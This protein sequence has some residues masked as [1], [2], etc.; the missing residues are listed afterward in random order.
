MAG[1]L[2]GPASLVGPGAPA[3][4]PVLCP[5]RARAAPALVPETFPEGA[6]LGNAEQRMKAGAG[7][8]RRSSLTWLP[9][10]GLLCLPGGREG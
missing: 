8:Q 2:K 6:W 10:P 1:T 3:S 7:P 4:A 9:G 5:R